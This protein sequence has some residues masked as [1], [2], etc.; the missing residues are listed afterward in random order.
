M[1]RLTRLVATIGLV[2]AVVVVGALPTPATETVSTVPPNPVY[3][4][5]R[6]SPRVLVIG[7][8][9]SA[10]LEQKQNYA[11]L[12]DLKGWGTEVRATGTYTVVTHKKHWSFIYAY[13]EP[14]VRAVFVP[15]GTNDMTDVDT[16]AERGAV[17]S[18]IDDAVRTMAS[19]CVVWLGLNSYTS[20]AGRLYTNSQASTFNYYIWKN[21]REQ[22][23]KFSNLH[24]ADYNA[25][26]RGN[27]SV[28]AALAADYFKVHFAGSSAP[29][30]RTA[31]AE[32]EANQVDRYCL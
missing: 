24:Y 12:N 15:L 21:S 10:T 8:S 9:I 3:I 28:R 2:G 22:G 23:G 32:F 1:G 18:A 6:S 17:W 29:A 14:A 26:V 30:A 27:S 11:F 5:G 7:D 20:D 16:E 25:L 31:L 13:A 4:A 19:E